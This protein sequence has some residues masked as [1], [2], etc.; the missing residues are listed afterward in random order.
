LKKQWRRWES[1][2]LSAPIVVDRRE[3]VATEATHDDPR[4]C[5]VS[6]ST[7]PL[8]AIEIA[9]ADALTKAASAQRFDVVAQLAREARRLA[10]N[11]NVVRLD[12][13]TRQRH[14]AR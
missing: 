13:R 10:R 9:L 4:R 11:G 6:A 3:N 12:D 1:N 14:E 8:D 7:P 2:R 5:E